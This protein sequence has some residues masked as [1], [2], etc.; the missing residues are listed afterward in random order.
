MSTAE[1]PS[2]VPPQ[3]AAAQQ[4]TLTPPEAIVQAMA[5]YNSRDWAKAEQLCRS[6]LNADANI[7]SALNLLG[8]ITAQTQ[9]SKEAAE[10]FGRAIALM[11]NN[12]LVLNNLSG[13][14]K[15]LKRFEEAIVQIERAICIEPDHAQAYSNRG[16]ALEELRQLPAALASYDRAI[17]INAAHAEA[18]FNRGNVL[19]ALGQFDA[20]IANFDIAVSIRPDFAE[21]QWSRSLALLLVGDFSNGWAS[22]EW[23]WKWDAFS[24]P[25]RNFSQPLWL[26]AEAIK[27]KTLLLHSEQGLGD[28]IQFCRYAKYAADLGANVVM[29]V[30][31]PL[32]KLLQGLAGVAQFVETGGVLPAFDYH[33]PLLSLPLAFKTNLNTIPAP[34]P[35]LHSD[36]SKFDFWARKLGVRTKP[37]VGLVW[38]GGTPHKN[39]RN[40]S[41]A[42]QSLLPYLP[43]TIEYISLQM[44]VRDADQPALQSSAIRHFGE[45]LEDFADTA[46][47][48]DLM[49]LV[50]SVDTAVTHLAGSLGKR[51]WVLLPHLPDWRWLLDRADSPW[52]PSLKLYRQE[53]IADW[54]GVLERVKADLTML[55]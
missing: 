34:S 7:F 9:R 20:A 14:L 4:A 45:A 28:T 41:L 22:Y 32:V 37:R 39:D 48:C 8:A 38:S 36:G 5:A 46:A 33:C 54:T 13:A 42:L 29:E 25:K 18:H 24:S 50:I 3:P 16:L 35:Y 19:K 1:S 17:F 23:R 44:E 15:D 55:T 47:L 51:T 53:R 26:G 52:Y 49:D 21:A 12:I 2:A 11:P 6:V 10:L 43:D 31:K 27:G 40:R 30:P